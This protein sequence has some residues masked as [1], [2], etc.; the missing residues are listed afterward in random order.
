MSQKIA[1]CATLY[2]DFVYS[3]QQYILRL[4]KFIF[5]SLTF[6]LLRNFWSNQTTLSFG[7]EKIGKTFGKAK[8]AKNAPFNFSCHEVQKCKI[9]LKID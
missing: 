1:A 6:I 5:S 8:C 2:L 4:D 3:V 7:L 9:Y